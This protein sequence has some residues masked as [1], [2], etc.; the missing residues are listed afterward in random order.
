M[1]GTVPFPTHNTFYI[2]AVLD[3]PP[4]MPDT[5]GSTVLYVVV[6]YGMVLVRSYY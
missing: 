1:V 4:P 5:R 6:R 3:V 2:T